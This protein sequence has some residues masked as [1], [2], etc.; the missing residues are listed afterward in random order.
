MVGRLD[1]NAATRIEESYGYDVTEEAFKMLLQSHSIRST[2]SYLLFTNGTT[3]TD[4]SLTCQALTLP[5]PLLPAGDNVYSSH[6][7]NEVAPYM[8]RGTELIAWDF[9][10]H[11]NRHGET[12]QQVYAQFRTNFLDLGSMMIRVNTYLLH[13]PPPPN[14]FF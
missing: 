4:I 1:V 8:K 3:H 14:L 11:H 10:C 5:S 6:F 9:V 13:I 7:F 12:N 2:C